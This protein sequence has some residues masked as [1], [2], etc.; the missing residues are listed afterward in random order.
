[1]GHHD[2]YIH[3]ED[4]LLHFQNEISHTDDDIADGDLQRLHNKERLASN[5]STVIQGGIH[6]SGSH[7][8]EE[9]R[10]SQRLHCQRIQRILPHK[11][12]ADEFHVQDEHPQELVDATCKENLGVHSDQN[13]RT[14][15]SPM[16]GVH[17][18]YPTQ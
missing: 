7:R 6:S 13:Q 3:S 1:M 9:V 4:D 2:D 10:L 8:I 18:D 5:V 12:L 17:H 11:M 16:E 15:R 14:I